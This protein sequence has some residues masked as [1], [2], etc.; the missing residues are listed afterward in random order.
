V[1]AV[2][3]P[4]A[5]VVLALDDISKRFGFVP[6]L[7][8]ASLHVR[9]GNIHA[10]L[11]ENGAGKTTLMRVAFGMIPP[12]DGSIAMRGTICHFHSSAEA[13]SAG[14]GM[15]QQH[16][17]PVPTLSVAESVAL[18]DVTWFRGLRDSAPALPNVACV[19]SHR[20]LVFRSI[21]QLE[22]LIF[23]SAL[24]SGSNC[25]G[26]LHAGPGF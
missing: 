18:G 8:A 19:S 14:L 13:T 24:N 25:S 2:A 6:A 1:N 26:H 21:P 15:V 4:R 11:G 10:L 20:R 7:R 9:A 5:P 12:D 22:R 23:P 17:L 3:R 16:F